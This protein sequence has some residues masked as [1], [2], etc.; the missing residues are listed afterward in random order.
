MQAGILIGFVVS[1]VVATIIVNGAYQLFM[2]LIG[3]DAM[4]FS[5]K[6]KLVAI[7]VVALLIMGTVVKIFGID[8][9]Q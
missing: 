4:F 3:A 2:K 6:T 5:A 1:L 9:P 7:V 8:I